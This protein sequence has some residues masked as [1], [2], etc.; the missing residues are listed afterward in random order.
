V[1]ESW[2]CGWRRGG[3]SKKP[4]WRGIEDWFVQN[5]FDPFLSTIINESSVFEKLVEI[6]WLQWI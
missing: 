2:L 5:Q 4:G 6:G 1:V 3:L